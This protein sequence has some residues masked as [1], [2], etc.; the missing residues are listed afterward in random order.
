MQDRE[1]FRDR[2]SLTFPGDAALAGQRV[3]VGVDNSVISICQDLVKG[4]ATC[5]RVVQR[6]ATARGRVTAI[7]RAECS[8]GGADGRGFKL[9]AKRI[10][11][12]MGGSVKH[13]G[14]A[15]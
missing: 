1:L 6:S 9:Q 11:S 8:P 3:V 5:M 13:L 10:A 2:I 12:V 4:A 14:T 15:N 7:Q